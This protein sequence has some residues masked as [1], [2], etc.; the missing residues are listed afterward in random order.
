MDTLTT[1]IIYVIDNDSQKKYLKK[2]AFEKWKS[3]LDMELK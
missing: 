3:I 1:T 2:Y